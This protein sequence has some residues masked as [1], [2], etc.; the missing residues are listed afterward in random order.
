MIASLDSNCLVFV[1]VKNWSV[2]P[3]SELAYNL[4]WRREQRFR[5]AA[6]AY[7]LEHPEYDEYEKRFDLVVFEGKNR[8]PNH[9]EG[10]LT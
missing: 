8:L 6:E 10:V 9:I 2:F 4:N 7:L 1:E 5:Q 3:L